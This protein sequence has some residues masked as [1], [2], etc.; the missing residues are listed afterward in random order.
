M[1]LRDKFFINGQ[2]AAPSS[3]E[4]IDVHNAGTG[5]VMGKVPAGTEK[6]VEAA[7]AAARAADVAVVVVG[8]SPG[9]ESEG[10]DRTQ[11]E[12]PDGQAELIRAVACA[13]PRTVVVVVAGAPVAMSDWIDEVPAVVQAWF[14]GEQGGTAIGEVVFGDAV[15]SGRLPV[16]FPKRW[17]DSS[18]FPDYPGRD[19]VTHYTDGVFV[20]YRHLDRAGIEPQ[21]AF[22]HGLSYTTFAYSDLRVEPVSTA[23]GRSVRA[24]FLLRNTGAR[25][26][27]EVAQVYV[28]DPGAGL[29]RPPRELKAF[30]RVELA[31]GDSARVAFELDHSA[32]EYYDPV[33]A[34][35]RSDPGEFVIHVGASSRDLRL[36]QGVR[37]P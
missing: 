32:F 2:W 35:W 37:W 20:G 18:A 4:T 29:P 3:K 31:P 5:E 25:T 11:L 9:I 19:L 34:A 7:V 33:R 14:P 26:G 27:T 1:I 21:F 22:G 24:S 36:S 12:L 28:S 30:T 6:D 8:D 17:Q 10:F 16:S 23:T 13:N 15:P